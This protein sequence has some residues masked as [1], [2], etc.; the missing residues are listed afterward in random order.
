MTVLITLTTAG[1]NTG[2]FNLYSDV[3]GYLSAFAVEVSKSDLEAGYPSDAVPDGTTLIKVQ[4]VNSL[5][6]NYIELATGI[7]TTTTTTVAS[8]VE[9][10][11]NDC[12][13]LYGPSVGGSYTDSCSGTV[14]VTGTSA[15]FRAY[16]YLN[17]DGGNVNTSFDVVGISPGSYAEQNPNS[18]T[19]YGSYITLTPGTYSYNLSISMFDGIDSEGGIEWIQ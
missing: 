14:T 3:D 16:A 6:N 13:V 5:C 2:P 17:Q 10:S 18:G 4:S 11:N 15:Q 8:S 7:T 9:F 1:V 19:D 12:I